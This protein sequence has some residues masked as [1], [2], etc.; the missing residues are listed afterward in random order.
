MLG[1]DDPAIALLDKYICPQERMPIVSGSQSRAT[2]K[3]ST[4]PPSS[5]PFQLPQ[6]KY[7]VELAWSFSDIINTHLQ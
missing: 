2:V 4:L 7:I 6:S 3:S 5:V 1:S